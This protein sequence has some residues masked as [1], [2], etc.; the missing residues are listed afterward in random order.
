[1]VHSALSFCLA[2]W[3]LLL[4]CV[5]FPPVSEILSIHPHCVFRDIGVS[6]LLNAF[7]LFFPLSPSF[8]FSVPRL[9]T[10]SYARQFARS[11]RRARPLFLSP[12]FPNVYAMFGFC[13]SLSSVNF[14]I[15]LSRRFRA[16]LIGWPDGSFFSLVA[17]SAGCLRQRLP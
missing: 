1:M 14:G 7:S 10:F 13:A 15:T 12:T 17:I 2:G 11:V 4:A 9:R 6:S 5:L 8:D 3:D 16:R